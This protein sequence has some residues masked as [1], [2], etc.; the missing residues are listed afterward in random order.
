VIVQIAPSMRDDHGRLLHP[1][2]VAGM[3]AGIALL[4][5]TGLLVSV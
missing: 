5:V 4:Y 1:L 3:L 2:S